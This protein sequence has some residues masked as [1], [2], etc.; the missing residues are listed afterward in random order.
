MFIV[1]KEYYLK[2]CDRYFLMSFL[3]SNPRRHKKKKIQ[4]PHIEKSLSEV[5]YLFKEPANHCLR[6]AHQVLNSMVKS[7]YSDV[8]LNF[9]CRF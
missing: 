5:T 6:K 7:A 8:T 4:N 1:K 9:E 2:V 3:G